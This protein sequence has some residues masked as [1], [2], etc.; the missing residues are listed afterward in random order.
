[1]KN[2]E[3]DT[4]WDTYVLTLSDN[5]KR[6]TNTIKNCIE[7]FEADGF[8]ISTMNYSESIILVSRLAQNITYSTLVSYCKVFNGFIRTMSK[9]LDHPF[10][11]LLPIKAETN[12]QMYTSEAEFLTD[13]ESRLMQITESFATAKQLSETE[14]AEYRDSW[15]YVVTYLILQYYGLSIDECRYLRMS[16]IDDD[17]HTI[18]VSRNGAVIIKH[19]SN[20]AWTYI[21]Q[22]KD[23][24][25]CKHFW[26]AV[27][28]HKLAETGYL[29]RYT[30][31]P[32]SDENVVSKTQLSSAAY[33]F[34]KDSNIKRW[35]G[36]SG[37]FISYPN[38]IYN[39][40]D[41]CDFVHT[42]LS[43]RS[44]S[45]LNVRKHWKD[46]LKQEGEEI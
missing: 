39:A 7:H 46:F 28:V 12:S 6:C 41:L 27:V 22:Y 29:F 19:I 30:R 40:H 15:L 14:T 35:L 44:V 36:L 32:R 38:H 9:V 16:D 3:F 37:A 45:D 2:K 24:T 10:Q 42:Y 26:N 5:N 18:Q 43:D 8:D 20:D 31:T 11:K 17:R 13:I 21:K 23:Q 34:T 33:K 25:Y 1:M 4:C